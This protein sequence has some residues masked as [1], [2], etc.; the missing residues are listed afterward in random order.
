MPKS[1]GSRRLH[2]FAAIA[3]ALPLAAAAQT[4]TT[5]LGVSATVI[6]NCLV[7]ATPVAFANYD[8]LITTGNI[9]ATGTVRIRC[10]RGTTITSVALGN[11]TST[12]VGTRSMAGPGTERLLYELF[13]PSAATAGAACNYTGASVWGDSGTGLFNPSGAAPTNL[14]RDYNVCGRLALNQDV[15]AGSYADTVT[16]TVNF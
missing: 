16:V 14:F 13:K 10:T 2:A 8:P 12:V 4:A 9:D 5:N 6:K 7:Q 1:P 11:G 15:P 3:L